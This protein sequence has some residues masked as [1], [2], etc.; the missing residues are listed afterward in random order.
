MFRFRF[1]SLSYHIHICI[2]PCTY[3][4]TSGC[5][6]Q[7]GYTY[8]AFIDMGL[9]LSYNLLPPSFLF[10]FSFLNFLL[11]LP[12]CPCFL[13]LFLPLQLPLP[14]D[15]GG[16]LLGGIEKIPSLTQRFPLRVIIDFK[17]QSSGKANHVSRS[18]IIQTRPQLKD[19]SAIRSP[20]VYFYRPR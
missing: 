10:F 6:V 18:L 12:I 1:M 4:H 17:R 7:T 5:S 3:I 13:F 2:S 19:A 11:L 15:V 8:R 20:V 16:L 9:F 14:D